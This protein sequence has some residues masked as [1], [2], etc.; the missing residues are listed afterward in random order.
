MKKHWWKIA[1]VAIIVT[2][3]IIGVGIYF[4]YPILNIIAVLAIV[5]GSIYYFYC[6]WTKTE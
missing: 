2:L 1:I 5:V 6:Q 3:V 4:H